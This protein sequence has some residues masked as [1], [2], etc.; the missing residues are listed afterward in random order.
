[1]AA[2]ILII[3]AVVVGGGGGDGGGSAAKRPGTRKIG[4]NERSY[5]RKCQRAERG[6]RPMF[7]GSKRS[8]SSYSG[9]VRI[10]I[11]RNGLVNVRQA[12]DVLC[13]ISREAMNGNGGRDETGSSGVSVFTLE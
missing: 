7:A 5:S 2:S 8:E 3:V 12:R 10:F 1:V 13:I 4:N 9:V 11:R 6:G